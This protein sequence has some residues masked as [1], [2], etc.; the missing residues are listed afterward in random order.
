METQQNGDLLAGRETLDRLIRGDALIGLLDAPAAEREMLAS[1]WTAASRGS[2]EAFRLLGDC[3]LGS[4]RPL[5]AFSGVDPA[6]AGSRSWSAAARAFADQAEPA[7]EASLRAFAEAAALGDREALLMLARLT[8]HSP[9][10]NQRRA[11]ALLQT[12]NDPRPA[13]VYQIGLIQNWLGELEASL[14]SHLAAAAG[15]DA[16]A[17]FELHILFAQGLGVSEDPAASWSWLERAAAA[18]QPRALYNLG[19]AFASGSRG[20]VDMRKAAEYYREAAGLGHGRA[21]ATLAVML[22]QG[23]AEGSRE[24]AGAWLD[25]AEELGV[26]VED[27]LEAADL[28]DPRAQPGSG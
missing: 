21:A 8:K 9:E 27:L 24:E 17:M 20:E 7:L 10:A 16:D 25:R 26:Y 18:R 15:G 28:P 23:A 19:A 2:A 1:L 14:A 11:L 5:G 6:D 4:L 13:E 22:L 12:L 3:Y